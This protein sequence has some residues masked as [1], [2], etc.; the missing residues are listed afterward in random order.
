I[1]LF[2]VCLPHLYLDTLRAPTTGEHVQLDDLAVVVPTDAVQPV[3]Y[4]LGG[5]VQVRA[6]APWCDAHDPH[7]DGAVEHACTRSLCLPGDTLLILPRLPRCVDDGRASAHRDPR[8]PLA[9][10]PTG[11][12]KTNH[13]PPTTLSACRLSIRSRMRSS[14]A[15]YSSSL[16]LTHRSWAARAR[17][18]CSGVRLDFGGP[19]WL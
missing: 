13:R 8:A 7:P 12:H 15:R 3:E 1:P 10:R 2:S 11:H 17:L 6:I 18:I 9:M 19:S 16:M 5:I 4:A 14:S